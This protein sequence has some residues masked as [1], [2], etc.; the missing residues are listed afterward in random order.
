ME[1]QSVKNIMEQQSIKNKR[2]KYLN[3]LKH[4]IDS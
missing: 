4:K 1:Q 3:Q 2:K